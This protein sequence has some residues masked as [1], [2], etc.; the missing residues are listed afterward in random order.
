MTGAAPLRLQLSPS[1]VLAAAIFGAH[2]AAATG[3]ALALPGAAGW[4]LAVL[5]LALGAEAARDRALLRA[6]HST[7][8]IELRGPDEVVLVLADGRRVASAVGP[9]RWVTRSCVALPVRAPRRRT[10]LVTRAMLGEP[11]FRLLR[12]WARWSRVPGVAAGQPRA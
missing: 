2:L 11:A 7:R 5:V 1:P 9:G 4:A 3:V 10:V 12:L 8:A 6:R